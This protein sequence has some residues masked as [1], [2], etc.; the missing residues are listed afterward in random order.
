MMAQMRAWYN[1]TTARHAMNRSTKL[2]KVIKD[3]HTVE[4]YT[5]QIMQMRAMA[6]N[7]VEFLDSVPAPVD[8]QITGIDYGYIGSIGRMHELLKESME[9][10]DQI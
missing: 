3:A 8:G 1:D 9:V 6:E 5:K 2:V 7:L 4:R 10:A